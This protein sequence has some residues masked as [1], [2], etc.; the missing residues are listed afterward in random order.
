MSRV[1]QALS[2]D[3]NIEELAYKY[4][5]VSSAGHRKRSFLKWWIRKK[6]KFE[7]SH[8]QM[9]SRPLPKHTRPF[10]MLQGANLYPACFCEEPCVSCGGSSC[11]AVTGTS[12][13][14][15]AMP[16]RSACTSV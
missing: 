14:N 10:S 3:V 12:D 6:R 13:F 8:S 1:P 15:F 9:Q 4:V 11:P 7:A 16:M 5:R 2:P